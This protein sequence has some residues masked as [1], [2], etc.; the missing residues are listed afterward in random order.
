MRA[1]RLHAAAAT[2][3]SARLSLTL[4]AIA[5]CLLPPSRHL[6]IAAAGEI[7]RAFGHTPTCIADDLRRGDGITAYV[8][9]LARCRTFVTALID[10]A[11]ISSRRLIAAYGSS[12][13]WPFRQGLPLPAEAA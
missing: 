7:T 12:A 13:D 9:P 2:P 8:L 4:M 11:A 5:R 6:P 10:G 3:A 1:G